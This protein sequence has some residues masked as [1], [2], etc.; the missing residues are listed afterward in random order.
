MGNERCSIIV[1]PIVASLDCTLAVQRQ[2]ECPTAVVVVS[3]VVVVAGGVDVG[4]VGFVAVAGVAD[5]FVSVAGVVDVGG[6]FVVAVA[7]VAE[8]VVRVAVVLIL[9]VLSLLQLLC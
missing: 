9:V 5:D 1:L 4:G 2:G 8:G 6:I 7:V 3:L